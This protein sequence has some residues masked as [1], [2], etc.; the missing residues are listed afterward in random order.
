MNKQITLKLIA[1]FFSVYINSAQAASISVD[2]VPGGVINGSL[3]IPFTPPPPDPTFDILI[4][5]VA[6]L[7]GFQFNL[8]F[9]PSI[10]NISSID[11]GNIFG[12]DTAVFLSI[13]DFNNIT[14]SI[15]FSET[16]LA[17]SGLNIPS[18]NML[19][20]A[21]L[22]TIHFQAIGI[23]TSSLDLNNTVLS[24]SASPPNEITPVTENDGQVTFQAPPVIQAPE[25]SLVLLSGLG[26][27]SLISIQR[28][29]KIFSV[30]A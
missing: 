1:V 10:L 17:L 30:T 14:G 22:A 8:G 9:D 6:D 3:T 23:G 20:P 15:S 13:S 16:S 25:P 29:A 12:A 21:I 28:K 5:D 27:L 2:M 19:G 4:N 26:L 7:A 24:D 11:S 18:L